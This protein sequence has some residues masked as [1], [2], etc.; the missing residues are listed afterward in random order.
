V[1][2]LVLGILNWRVL[3]LDLE[4]GAIALSTIALVHSTLA[5][6]LQRATRISGARTAA[7]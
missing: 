1:L 2:V 3:D 7:P 4:T 6:R 5:A